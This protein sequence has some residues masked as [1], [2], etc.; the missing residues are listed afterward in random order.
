MP[1]PIKQSVTF[2]DLSSRFQSTQTVAASPSAGTETVVAT[3]TLAGFGDLGVMSGVRLHGWLAFTVGT[4]GDGATV[5]IRQTDVNGS[6]VVSSGQLT[7]S[8]TNLVAFDVVG[9]DAAPGVGQYALTLT[10]H[11]GAAA[12]TVSACHLGAIII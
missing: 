5:R 2:E 10:V 3:L 8:A 9:K 6:V 12:S 4:S 11:S 1:E 7:V